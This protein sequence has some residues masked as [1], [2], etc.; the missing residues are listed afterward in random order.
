MPLKHSEM[1]PSSE[2]F[3]G[4]R[5]QLLLRLHIILTSSVLLLLFPL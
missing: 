1:H 2:T 3:L 5:S 4:M